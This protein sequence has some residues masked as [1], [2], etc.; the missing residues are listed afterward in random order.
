MAAM[1]SMIALNVNASTA[2][3]FNEEAP[4]IIKARTIK[5][6]MGINFLEETLADIQG[7]EL[8]DIGSLSN[9]I[10]L[11][12]NAKNKIAELSEVTDP[13]ELNVQAPTLGRSFVNMRDTDLP[14]IMRCR[15]WTPIS[16]KYY[17]MVEDVFSFLLDDFQSMKGQF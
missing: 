14:E 7:E 12:L 11:L 13:A 10:R 15:R 5:G 2:I 4:L 3:D 9:M 6:G 17:A 16:K 1:I 8:A